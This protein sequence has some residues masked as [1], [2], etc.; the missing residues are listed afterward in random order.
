MSRWPEPPANFVL[1]PQGAGALYVATSMQAELN[2]R[3][4]NDW[5]AWRRA[6]AGGV[7]SSGRG[8]TAL[9]EGAS[10]PRW[11]LKTLRRGGW[12]ARLWRDRYASAQRPVN[13]LAASED[14]SQRGIPTARPVALI[15]QSGLGGLAQGAMA[16]EELEGSVDL[17]RRARAHAVT[18][19][20][21]VT[22]IGAVRLM[23]DRGVNHVDLNLGNIL[24]RSRTGV[25]PEAFLI[26]FDCAVIGSGPRPF[27]DRQAAIRRLERSCAKLTGEPG[28]LGPGSEDLWYTIYAGDDAGLARSF[29]RG[30]AA[31]RLA[32]AVHRMGWRRNTP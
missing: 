18:Q 32:L 10:G 16:F 17:A 28:P 6:L 14:V 29:A 3:G 11:R 5:D 25:P 9:V 30:R 31:G 22:A 24:L 13:M 26:D 19:V 15:V 2:A 23:H 21:L 1:V 7:A 27:G 8:M 20:D 12:L 4:L